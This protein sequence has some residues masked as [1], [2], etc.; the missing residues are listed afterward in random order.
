MLHVDTLLTEIEDEMSDVTANPSLGLPTTVLRRISTMNTASMTGE[1]EIVVDAP[2][3]SV[4]AAL[5]EPEQLLQWG[6]TREAVKLSAIEAR[7][8]E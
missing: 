4:F 1:R 2:V 8:T 5:T 7:E 3:A 6:A